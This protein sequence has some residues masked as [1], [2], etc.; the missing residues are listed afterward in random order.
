MLKPASNYLNTVENKEPEEWIVDHLV[1][2]SQPLEE[3]T[4]GSGFPLGI[5]IKLG[6]YTYM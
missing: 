5:E 6:K 2:F 1:L 4:N 3:W